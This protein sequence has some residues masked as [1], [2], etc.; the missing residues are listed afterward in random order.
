MFVRDDAIAADRLLRM[1]Y[2]ELRKVAAWKIAGES[3]QTLQPTALVHEAW[4]RLADSQK[5]DWRNRAHFYGAAAEAMRRILIDR[6][7]RRRALRRGGNA[8]HV[9][10]SA[11]DLEAPHGVDDRLLALDDAMRKFAGLDP[12]KAELV[13]LRYYAGLGLREAAEALEISE[14]T[15]KRWWVF[16]RAWLYAEIRAG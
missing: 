4:L 2:A 10:V 12:A 16:A 15:A 11:L 9:D 14:T 7:R 13:R 8:P 6:A 3:G 1:V 5:W